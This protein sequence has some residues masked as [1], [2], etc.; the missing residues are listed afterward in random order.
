MSLDNLEK[1]KSIIESRLTNA[2]HEKVTLEIQFKGLAKIK[3]PYIMPDG[4]PMPVFIRKTSPGRYQYTDL[5]NIMLRF[6][7]DENERATLLTGKVGRRIDELSSSC[8]LVYDEGELFL[9]VRSG[10]LGS[11]LLAFTDALTSIVKVCPT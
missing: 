4:E 8:G 3:L 10:N 1:S 11:R 2:L 9:Q 5:G 6:C 7:P